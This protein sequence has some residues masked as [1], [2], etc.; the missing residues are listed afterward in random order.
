MNISFYK[1]I[2]NSLIEKLESIEH[3]P[4]K[5]QAIQNVSMRLSQIETGP[6]LDALTGSSILKQLN[7]LPTEELIKLA[8]DFYNREPLS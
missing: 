3:E 7:E 2:A 8:Y 1:A 5:K 6:Y 4:I